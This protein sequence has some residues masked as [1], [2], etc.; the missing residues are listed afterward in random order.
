AHGQDLDGEEVGRRQAVPMSGEERLPGRLRAALGC[1]LDAVVPEDSLDRVAG[2]FVAEAV[3]PA[4]DSRVAP[5]RVLRRH[6]GHERGDVGR[7]AG[8]T[9]GSRL[10]AGVLLGDEAA[11]PTEDRVRG[12]Y[13]C[14][15]REAT[16]TEGLSLDSQA[17]PLVVSEP[18][19][20]GSALG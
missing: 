13:A 10:R 19:L 4:A 7:G 18:E 16:A 15:V 8:A 9:G 11:V 14:D 6:R 12:D 17:A 5:R 2:D 3:Q 1:G 20:A